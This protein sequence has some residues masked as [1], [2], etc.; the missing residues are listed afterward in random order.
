MPNRTNKAT[1]RWVNGE[2]MYTPPLETARQPPIQPPPV[3]PPQQMQPQNLMYAPGHQGPSYQEVFQNS[4]YPSQ[5]PSQMNGAPLRLGTY[6]NYIENI[7][8]PINLNP[9]R[10]YPNFSYVR[11][12][13]A[14]TNQGPGGLGRHPLPSTNLRDFSLPV[15]RSIP[16]SCKDKPRE[17]SAPAR[18]KTPKHW[19]SKNRDEMKHKSKKAGETKDPSLGKLVDGVDEALTYQADKRANARLPEET[20]RLHLGNGNERPHWDSR[21]RYA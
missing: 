21:G 16:R 8:L 19:L 13:P 10:P 3:A 20:D 7:W 9:A 12:R 6:T 2:R 5:H 4:G 1:E 11:S 14:V 18:P 15:R 17:G